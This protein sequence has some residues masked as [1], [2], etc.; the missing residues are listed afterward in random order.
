MNKF[1]DSDQ[2]LSMVWSP[3][4]EN[5]IFSMREIFCSVVWFIFFISSHSYG[6][7]CSISS[8]NF[9]RFRELLVEHL[10][11]TRKMRSDEITDGNRNESD[12]FKKWVGCYPISKRYSNPR[13]CFVL[14]LSTECIS[15]AVKRYIWITEMKCCRGNMMAGLELITTESRHAKYAHWS[16][17]SLNQLSFTFARSRS[18][19]CKASPSPPVRNWSISFSTS[20]MSRSDVNGVRVSTNFFIVSSKFGTGRCGS[21]SSFPNM[22]WKSRNTADTKWLPTCSKPWT[23]A[24]GLHGD[25]GVLGRCPPHD[26]G[27]LL[28]DVVRS[29][30]SHLSYIVSTNF[31][32]DDMTGCLCFRV[33]LLR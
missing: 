24:P 6:H 14:T 32:M 3:S 20:R 21:S 26:V 7:F 4:E 17:H 12:T 2:H 5:S 28:L 10:S 11:T 15:L 8:K 16:H 33:V 19:P 25:V 9:F 27:E 30:C 22:E 1:F 23:R 13:F 29:F 31:D 18:F